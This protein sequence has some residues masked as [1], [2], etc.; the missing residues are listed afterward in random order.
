[1]DKTLSCK[2][3]GQ[4]F[5]FTK[6][7]QE[8]YGEKNFPDPIRCGDCRKLKKESKKKNGQNNEKD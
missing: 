3:C 5:V 4:E 2:D 1:M 8:F 6:G 7:E